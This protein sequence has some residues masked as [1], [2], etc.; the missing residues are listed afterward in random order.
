M[1]H[2]ERR[3]KRLFVGTQRTM[4]GDYRGMTLDFGVDGLIFVEI[5]IYT[6]KKRGNIYIARYPLY[7]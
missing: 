4:L 2:R 6:A 7:F 3:F 1:I 5:Q